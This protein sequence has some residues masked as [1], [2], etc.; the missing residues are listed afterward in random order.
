VFKFYKFVENLPAHQRKYFIRL[1][2][3]G[4]ET[5]KEKYETPL[6]SARKELVRLHSKKP[7]NY[8]TLIMLREWD[9]KRMKKRYKEIDRSKKCMTQKR[10]YAGVRISSLYP[11][12]N[13]LSQMLRIL[14]IVHAG[15]FIWTYSDILKFNPW[16][17]FSL[18]FGNYD[19][20]VKLSKYDRIIRVT[21]RHHIFKHR[22]DILWFLRICSSTPQMEQCIYNKILHIPL[23]TFNEFVIDMM[24][25]I[26]NSNQYTNIKKYAKKIL[27]TVPHKN[28]IYKVLDCKIMNFKF[29]GAYIFI[30]QIVMLWMIFDPNQSIVLWKKYGLHNIKKPIVTK[31]YM[32]RL[33]NKYF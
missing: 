8:K 5:C 4:A 32:V 1:Y 20:Q 23:P 28:H 24:A 27:S 15:G 11:T 2:D 25:I 3:Y 12:K 30:Y 26:Y 16:I 7:N 33:L 14:D 10:D 31:Q 13:E 18:S 19:G 22:G 6:I 17:T 21:S 9:I 29:A